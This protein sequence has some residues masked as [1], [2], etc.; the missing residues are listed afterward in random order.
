[1][2][3]SPEFE[4]LKLS[5]R[6]DDPGNAITEAAGILEKYQINWDNLFERADLHE[7][8]PQLAIFINKLPSHLI[9]VEFKEKINQAY[10]VNLYKQLGNVAEFFRINKILENAGIKVVPFKGF[11][12]AYSCYGNIGDRESV[13]VDL[14]TDPNDLEKIQHNMVLQG[15]QVEDFFKRYTLDKIK[16]KFG[17]YNFDKI[18]N[19]IRIFHFEFQWR[20]SKP[21]YELGININDLRSQIIESSLQNRELQVFTP[22]ADFLLAAM[23][24]GGKDPLIELKQVY[25][26]ALILK[27]H[28]VLRWEWILNTAENYKIENVIYVAARLAFE[29]TGVKIPNEILQKTQ[30]LKIKRMAENRLFYMA[31]TPQEWDKT[32]FKLNNWLFRIRSRT[33]IKIK[34]KLFYYITGLYSVNILRS[35]LKIVNKT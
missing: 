22:S 15:Y 31:K 19:N 1:M 17:E 27:K 10:Q 13:D 16:R 23:H 2:M 25:D 9:D 8:K 5:L 18:E 24:H 28:S 26:I 30:S 7:I 6:V 12:I 4:L 3:S 33:G 32:V 14:F 34:L 20:I 21:L 35:F 11:W 29:I